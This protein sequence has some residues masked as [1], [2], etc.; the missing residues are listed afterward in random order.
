M[1]INI[2]KIVLTT[3]FAY[4]IL[5]LLIAVNIG[6]LTGTNPNNT[7]IQKF[8]TY[9]VGIFLNNFSFKLLFSALVSIIIVQIISYKKFNI[10]AIPLLIVSVVCPPVVAP[11]LHNNAS[12]ESAIRNYIQ[13][14]G[15]PYQSFFAVLNKNDTYNGTTD[16]AVLWIDDNGNRNHT[17]TTSMISN[18]TYTVS[19]RTRV[20]L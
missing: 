9:G 15:N 5:S 4:I 3:F 11:L 2:K 7:L 13:N 17:C 12:E 1:K 10:I 14:N 20:Y 19:C 8:T 6:Y 18:G 16:Y